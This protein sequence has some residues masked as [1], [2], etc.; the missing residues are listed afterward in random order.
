LATASGPRGR[1][2]VAH[3]DERIATK[4]IGRSV[5]VGAI[6]MAAEEQPAAAGAD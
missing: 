5:V 6:A 4:H 3:T 1:R 2:A